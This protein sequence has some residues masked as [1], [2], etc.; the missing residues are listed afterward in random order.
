VHYA[1]NKTRNWRFASAKKICCQHLKPLSRI[2]KEV[3]YGEK[4]ALHTAADFLT[5]DAFDLNMV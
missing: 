1:Y 3:A 5:I 2:K 4:T